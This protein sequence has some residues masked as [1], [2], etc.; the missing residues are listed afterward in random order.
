MNENSKKKKTC[1]VQNKVNTFFK[2]SSR[3]LNNIYW[4]KCEMK[5]LALLI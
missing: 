5:A 1:A 2:F 3:V 4:P